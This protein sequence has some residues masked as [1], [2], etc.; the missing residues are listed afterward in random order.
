VQSLRMR[1]GQNDQAG[2]QAEDREQE[3]DQDKE[4]VTQPRPARTKP[5]AETRHRA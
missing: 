5:R 2:G 4:K 3:Q 1:I